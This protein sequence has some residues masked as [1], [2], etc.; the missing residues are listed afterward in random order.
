MLKNVLTK[1]IPET[2]LNWLH[3]LP[4]A[5]LCIR[6]RSQADIAVS[7]DEMMFGLPF[8]L[9]PY[10]NGNYLDGEEATQK[11]LET[12]GKTSEV[13]EAIGKTLGLGICTPNLSSRYKCA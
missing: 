3:C 12:I 4:L 5:L 7:H 10:S 9:S 2:K 8:L 13:L 6:T 1:L 11:Y